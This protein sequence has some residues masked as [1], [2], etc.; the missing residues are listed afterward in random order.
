MPFLSGETPASPRA[1]VPVR[2]RSPIRGLPLTAAA[3]LL[4][5]A[6][7]APPVGSAPTPA[8]G[9]APAGHLLIVGGGRQ[10]A[11]LVSRFVELAGGPGRARIA[12][13]PLASGIPEQTGPAKAE[14]L[15]ALGADVFILNP[16]RAEAESAGTAE[17]LAD[18]TG[19]WFTG[20]DQARITRAIAGTPLLDAIR[21]RYREGAVIGGTSA[22]AAIMSDS[23]L[24][25]EQILPGEDTI[26]YHGDEYRRIA[27]GAI[28]IVPGLG[29]LPGTIVDQHFIE[30]ERHNRLLSVVLER[31][32]LVGVGIAESTAIEVAPDGSWRVLGAGGVL[33]YDARR[34]SVTGSGAPLGAADLRV[35]LLTPG[36]VYLPARGEVRLP[37]DSALVTEAAR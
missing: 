14:D 13:I 29:F 15:E 5:Q 7:C 30:R 9:D 32:R 6:G 10:P 36:S 31:P 3:A 16:T 24:T 19:V 21:E 20:G 27:R 23:M 28:R 4:L 11:E 34:A 8:S 2:R 25:G 1:V 18:V 37:E 35:H 33:I 17:R 12:V 22:G 26:G